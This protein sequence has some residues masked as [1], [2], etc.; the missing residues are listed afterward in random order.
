M[1]RF[2]AGLRQAFSGKAGNLSFDA[3]LQL[4]EPGLPHFHGD[5]GF[6]QINA[7]RRADTQV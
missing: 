1:G 3:I 2:E 4:R 6:P 7:D 5:T